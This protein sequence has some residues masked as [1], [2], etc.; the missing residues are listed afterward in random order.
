MRMRPKLIIAFA[1][2]ALLPLLFVGTYSFRATRQ[3]NLKAAQEAMSQQAFAIALNLQKLV[4][5][6]QKEALFLSGLPAVDGMMRAIEDGGY[7]EEGLSSVQLWKNRLD[8]T[9]ISLCTQK[10]I[11]RSIRLVDNAGVGLAQVNYKGGEAEKL[12]STGIPMVSSEEFF[13]N[14]L[15][16]REGHV[17]V[18][19]PNQNL[20][21]ETVI[22]CSTP[23]FHPNTRLRE[24]ALVVEVSMED[25]IEALDE[26]RQQESQLFVLDQQGVVRFRSG[27]TDKELP[28]TKILNQD[29]GF[30]PADPWGW[31]SA[32]VTV[33]MGNG[34]YWKVVVQAKENR[35][36]GRVG[37]FGTYLLATSLVVLLLCVAAGVAY[38]RGFVSPLLRIRKTLLV[39]GK[40]EHPETLEVMGQDE[41]GEMT[42]V[43]NSLVAGLAKTSEF[44]KEIGRGRLDAEFSPL[45]QGDILGNSLLEMRK[46]LQEARHEEALRKQEDDKQNWATQG[47]ARF[48]DIL[49]RNNDEIQVLS[50]DITQNMVEY[51]GVNQGGLF[52]IN[53]RDQSD[54]HIE[55]MATIAYDR[56]RSVIRRIEME[57]GLIGR[58]V[59]E[60]LTIYLSEIP[61]DYIFIT[62][63]LGQRVPNYLLLVPLKVNEETF[64]VIELASFNPFPEHH[65]QFVEKV[66][67]NIASTLSSVRVNEQTKLLL[68]QS[69]MQSEQMAAQEE[70]MRQNLEELQAT[71]EESSR[72][73]AE[74]TSVLN[75][76]SAS[77][78]V[79]EFDRQGRV[80]T[81]NREMERLSGLPDEHFL[82]KTFR[83]L[84][85]L[86]DDGSA[87]EALW[88]KVLR[89][90]AQKAMTLYHFPQGDVWLS[91]TYSPVFDQQGRIV[92]VINIANDITKSRSQQEA[93][94][95]QAEQMQAQ[96][97]E[98]R[99]NFEQL[100][101][102]Q[103][104][105][106]AREA[107]FN[108]IFEAINA[109]ALFAEFDTKGNILSINDR[110]LQL[111]G[112]ARAQIVGTNQAQY[113]LLA[114][115]KIEYERFWG[116]LLGGRTRTLVNQMDING[117]KVWLSET[118][119]PVFDSDGK[120][121]KVIDIATDITQSKLQEE[122]L[123]EQAEQMQAQEEELK[124][125][126]E[127]MEKAQNDL[128]A[129]EQEQG[130]VIARLLAENQARI[131][132]VQ[133]AKEEFV[134]MTAAVPG[135]VFQ[136]AMDREGN[137]RFTYTSQGSLE[138]FGQS[139]D[140]F[141]DF[142]NYLAL[143]EEKE[144]TRH[145]AS[146]LKA[147]DH[148]QIWSWQGRV[149]LPNGKQ[150][151]IS[152][153]A[154]PES[155]P[156]GSALFSGIM[157]DIT[158]EK[159]RQDELD[160]LARKEVFVESM[161]SATN[162]IIFYKDSHFVYRGCNQA[163]A[164]HWQLELDEVA[165][166]TDFDF[167]DPENA[168]RYREHDQKVASM[169]VPDRVTE[170]KTAK[171][172]TR[173]LTDTKKSPIFDDKGN[174]L[175]IIGIARDLTAVFDLLAPPPPQA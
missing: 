148:R 73:E 62:S 111:L 25:V 4:E 100:Q 120:I 171:D 144:R 97:E 16:L 38:A 112:R 149:S 43:L 8:E 94:E 135:M 55:Q 151:W 23:V 1:S 107:Q 67:E 173:R 126:F 92:K 9:L 133:R 172:G 41:L 139:A 58:C 45:S 101:E 50:H 71:Q 103:E 143:I 88:E 24:G 47:I 72:R 82:G 142:Q 26:I 105:S 64:G 132:Q 161:L 124:V 53:D 118:Y 11:Y 85:A 42:S 51:L 76:I 10:G 54:K 91:E 134:Q 44:A 131:D 162:D 145:W 34:S 35:L 110:Y 2:V 56:R 169:G 37:D 70:E 13:T 137:S 174:F 22:F 63:G 147:L 86:I 116:D 128:M 127:M 87:M 141:A 79:V 102:A 30:L 7:D 78:V 46:S 167:I 150:K 129:R 31:V 3:S 81:A 155:L 61:N 123:M 175:G 154:R 165:G 136:L 57:E 5:A 65:I 125:H 27:E 77:S 168:Q 36:M 60:G 160:R 115:D 84:S 122:A 157:S 69:R 113:N 163:F 21:G 106:Q 96:E 140:F 39:L 52:V 93:L 80:L 90:Q 14:T 158:Q 49:R 146:L 170:W 121:E 18:L 153:K 66:G 119:S 75:A 15:L 17:S 20:A 59:D 109:A 29:K 138:L 89:G 40:G 12:W 114:Q 6:G 74:I 98:M 19:P 130:V 32:F 108:G 95:M 152:C 159:Q 28:L 83:D 48:S 104:N 117:R 33:P 68:Q 166:K 156:D 99:V 164:D